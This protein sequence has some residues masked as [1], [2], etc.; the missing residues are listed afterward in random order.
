LKRL[1]NFGADAKEGIPRGFYET[2]G[3]V[4]VFVFAFA[5]SFVAFLLLFFVRVLRIHFGL[6][7]ALDLSCFGLG[8]GWGPIGMNR[9]CYLKLGLGRPSPCTQSPGHEIDLRLPL[10]PRTF[11]WTCVA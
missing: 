3:D 7:Y 10:S 11:A 8:A 6:L 4:K 1:R 5:F 2:A 9:G